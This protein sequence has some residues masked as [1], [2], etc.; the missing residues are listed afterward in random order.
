MKTFREFILEGRSREEADKIRQEKENPSDW[1]LNNAG[2]TENPNW[3]PKPKSQ[4]KAERERRKQRE[5]EL[6]SPEDR[7]GATKKAKKLNDAGLEGHHTTPL[8]YSAKLKASMSPEEWE[9]RVRTDA[10]QGIYHGHHPKNIMGTVN[11]NTPESR[12]KTGILHRKGGA[13]EIEDKTKDITSSS[14]PHKELIAAA[15]RMRLRAEAERK[16][17]MKA[18]TSE[19]E[20]RMDSA[21]DKRVDDAS[22]A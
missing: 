20:A 15:Q 16:K 2:S 13:H 17:K 10:E 6:S 3:R 8:H 19:L 11:K 5:M 18:K 7:I 9:E 21:Y 4:G 12:A 22:N 14:I 1:Y